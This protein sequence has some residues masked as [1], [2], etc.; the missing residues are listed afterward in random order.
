M[1]NSG[2]TREFSP[3]LLRF[4]RQSAGF[5]YFV[6]RR[7]RPAGY[8]VAVALGISGVLGVAQPDNG[9]LNVNPIYLTFSFSLGLLVV[10]LAAAILRRPG[11][12]TARRELPRYATAGEVVHGTVQLQNRGQRAARSVG[13]IE[14]PPDPRPSYDLF[15]KTREPGE[16]K[17]NAF[18]RKFA[19]YRWLW[20]VDRLQ[21]FEGGRSS[22]PVDVAAGATVEVPLELTP[23]RR[24]VIRLDDLRLLLPDP[25]GLFQRCTKISAPPSTLTVL[26]ARHRLPPV[27]LPG[28]GRFQIGGDA[29]TN[30]IGNSGEFVS[31]RDYRPGDPIRQIHWKSWARTGRPIVRELEDTFYP[32]YGLVLDTFPASGQE[33]AFE[34][35]VSIAASFAST[36]DTRESLLDL[37]FIKDQA[38]TVTVG[39]GI[40]RPEVL[41]EVLAGVEPETIPHFDTLANLVLKYREELTSCL[42]VLCGWSDE[43]A[44]FVRKLTSQGLTCTVLATGQGPAPEGFPGHWIEAGQ[45]SR[46]LGALPIRL[47]PATAG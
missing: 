36:I 13:L 6:R 12:L 43:R 30:A 1:S 45:L 41:L 5:N 10:G 15:V 37:M 4:Y 14:T 19:Y 8:G 18:D 47:K 39:R 27:E 32:R 35:A 3:A 34:D 46:D 38:H 42:V 11:R 21:L 28:S 17:R 31:L 23:A 7:I 29:A 24:G 22:H 25:I 44:A 16:A 33:L 9:A 26:P 40:A 2:T 20:L